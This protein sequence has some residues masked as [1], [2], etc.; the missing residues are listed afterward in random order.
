MA[1]SSDLVLSVGSATQMNVDSSQSAIPEDWRERASRLL[2]DQA[3]RRSNWIEAGKPA[4]GTCGKPH[5][6]PCRPQDFLCVRHQRK[7]ESAA[8]AKT[9]PNPWSK[10]EEESR[11]KKTRREPCACGHFHKGECRFPWCTKKP[12]CG[13]RH[14]PKSGCLAPGVRNLAKKLTPGEQMMRDA[15]R[16]ITTVEEMDNFNAFLRRQ[17]EVEGQQKKKKKTQKAKARAADLP[18]PTAAAA[19]AAAED[20]DAVD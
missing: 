4:C 13:F 5:P 7:L 9:A 20:R 10:G 18:V 2:N 14:H 19:A 6:Q 1:S 12:S 16:S 17:Y 15:M 8:R 3:L 11:V